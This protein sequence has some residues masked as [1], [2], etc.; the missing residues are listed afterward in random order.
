MKKIILTKDAVLKAPNKAAGSSGTLLIVQDSVG[1]HLLSLPAGH[2]GNIQIGLRPNSITELEWIKDDIQVIWKSVIATAEGVIEPPSTINNLVTEL[3]DASGARIKWDAPQGFNGNNFSA[4]DV[5]FLCISSSIFDSTSN[6]QG[7]RIALLPS[8]S[9]IEETYIIPNL[10]A[11][12]R[13]YAAIFSK[14]S[15][16]GHTLQ[17]AISNVTT[18]LTQQLDGNEVVPKRI[19]LSP[20]RIFSST[21]KTH[22]MQGEMLTNFPEMQRMGNQDYIIDNNGTPEGIA[23]SESIA[24][25]DSYGWYYPLDWYNITE[26]KVY[27]DLNGEYDLD[28]AYI[29]LPAYNAMNFTLY[30][31]YDTVNLFKMFDRRDTP[32]IVP[33][34]GGW[35][36]IPL[37]I[38]ARKN[39][40][41]VVMGLGAGESEIHGITFYGTRKSKLEIKGTKHKRVNQ[42]QYFIDK[43]GTNTF[44]NE[45]ENDIT[46]LAKSVREYIEPDWF[47]PEVFRQQGSAEGKTLADLRGF[48]LGIS[49]VFNIKAEL[50]NL[51]A[52]GNKV[53]FTTVTSPLCYRTAGITY[54]NKV[55]PLDYGLD[56]K[57][58]S[59]TTNPQSYKFMS[60][61]AAILAAILGSNTENIPLDLID[62]DGGENTV[63]LDLIKHWEYNNEVDEPYGGM[64]GYRTPQELAAELSAM[65]DGHKGA[66]GEFMGIKSGDPNGKLLMPGLIN[67]NHSYVWE[68]LKWW[69]L[70]RGL[71]DYPI[72]VINFHFYNNYQDLTDAPIYSTIPRWGLPPELGRQ[73]IDYLKLVNLRDTLAPNMAIWSTESGWTEQNGGVDSPP[74][75]TP[76]LR[77]LHKSVWLMRMFLMAESQNI[78]ETYQ[79]MFANGYGPTVDEIENRKAREQFICTGYMDGTTGVYDLNRKPL[80]A[81]WYITAFR[82]DMI[83]YRY[84]HQVIEAGVVVCN[85]NP[86]ISSNPFLYV[87]A[88]VNDEGNTRLIAWMG[89]DQWV[90][91][92]ID[93]TVANSSTTVKVINYI[94]QQIK[95]VEH[96]TVLDVTSTIVDLNRKITLNISEFP[97]LIETDLVGVK[98]L[99]LPT[100]MKVQATSTSSIKLVWTDRNYGTNNTIIYY[101]RFSDRDYTLYTTAYYDEAE[102][103]I[104]ELN[105]KTQYFFKIQFADGE[106]VSDYT[107]AVGATT[108][109]ELQP[110]TNLS[111]TTISSNK[112]T[113]SF[114]YPTVDEVDIDNFILYRSSSVSGVYVMIKDIMKTARTV[115]DNGLVENT[116]YY[117]K[118]KSAKDSSLSAFSFAY[119]TTTSAPNLSP[120]VLVSIITNTIGN[121]LDFT[122]NKE[123]KNESTAI[124]AISV[125]ELTVDNDVY[126]H[127]VASAELLEDKSILR[128]HLN[129]EI[130]KDSVVTTSYDANIGNLMS[131][132]NVKVESFYDESVSNNTVGNVTPEG[133]QQLVAYRTLT[134][135]VKK[136]LVNT[137]IYDAES[138]PSTG[139]AVSE[140]KIAAGTAF[141]IQASAGN[142]LNGGWFGINSGNGTNPFN[143]M[144]IAMRFTGYA[145]G[146]GRFIAYSGAYYEPTPVNYT[147]LPL[148]RLRGT[149]T[150]VY[151]EASYDNGLTWIDIAPD[152]ALVQPLVDMYFKAY[153]DQADSPIKNITQAGMVN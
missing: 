48:R 10:N 89:T 8:M 18:F 114:D 36:K 44:L 135:G 83:G 57:N 6:P 43:M 65:W 47:M 30:G 86:V 1:G 40:K 25:Y 95:E 152:L 3:V 96:G 56:I 50:E 88:Y 74:D 81:Y 70:N 153:F 124:N 106:L 104:T 142:G 45:E 115:D 35:S 110:P 113:L 85:D 123:I 116:T 90:T 38:D 59:L 60:R 80:A 67:V 69:D 125:G 87:Q 29:N 66:L 144:L 13:Y 93:F 112:I 7:T 122:F 27:F 149:G 102:A 58:Y 33:V 41:Y 101:S 24:S 146:Y 147:V 15:S 20:D 62:Y 14:K 91:S 138:Y 139:Y 105:P 100:D 133:Q 97:T 132:L 134:D 42:N 141:I 117:Y 94:D 111:A 129:S 55:K 148:G 109:S 39:V 118:L 34:G 130:N 23:P 82:N 19:P 143:S 136:I 2:I 61:T 76:I 84:S 145:P 11:G 137:L 51:K 64:D 31:S 128:V 151:S 26:Y 16:F 54:N 75:A 99:L 4:S 5:Y 46:K 103:L 79:Y 77:G 68:M 140:Q 22:F 119:E 73:P 12:Q 63:G 107:L 150:R 17:S 120:P 53:V 92:D 52:L 131:N 9:G 126:A 21:V 98:K 71:G 108:Y 72:Q 49:H 28:Y 121:N 32:F 127:T 37:N 78:D